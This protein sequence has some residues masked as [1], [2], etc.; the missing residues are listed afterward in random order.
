MKLK[1]NGIGKCGVR[2]AYDLF[3]YTHDIPTSYEIRLDAKRRES[4]IQSVMEKLFAAPN[5][6]FR[7]AEEPEYVTIDSD[8]ENNE[9]VNKVL[10]TQTEGESPPIVRFPGR[11]Y[12]LNNFQGGC[13]FHVI[14]ERQIRSWKPIPEEIIGVEGISIYVVTFSIP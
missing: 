11:N 14:S 12:A 9:I 10:F 4:L 7:I 1:L 8:S 5:G 2:L 6:M 13:N 3:A